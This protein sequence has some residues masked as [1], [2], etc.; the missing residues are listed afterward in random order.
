MS[1]NASPEPGRPGRRQF[2]TGAVACGVALGLAGA[3]ADVAAGRATPARAA[4]VTWNGAPIARKGQ[5]KFQ[6]GRPGSG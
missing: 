5:V 2:L 1:S 3:V 4:P 6:L